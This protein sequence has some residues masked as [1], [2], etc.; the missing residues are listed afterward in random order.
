MLQALD[1]LQSLF[2]SLSFL[3]TTSPHLHHE[4][5]I[6]VVSPDFQSESLPHI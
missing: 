5:F 4:V 2:L 1:M 6:F 3:A